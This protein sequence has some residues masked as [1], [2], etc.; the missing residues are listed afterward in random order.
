MTEILPNLFLLSWTETQNKIIEL[1]NAFIINCTKNLPFLTNNSIRIEVDDDG[2]KE[3]IDKMFLAYPSIV[4]IIQEK[5]SNNIPIL[6]HCMAGQQRSPSIITAYLI[7]KHKVSLEDAI[8][9]IR[10]KRKSA[11]FWQVNFRDSLERFYTYYK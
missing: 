2:N 3:N 9:F 6:V 8:Y 4:E 1:P 11:F 10:S 5:L 7:A